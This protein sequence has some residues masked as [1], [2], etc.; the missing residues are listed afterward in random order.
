MKIKFLLEILLQK[1]CRGLVTKKSLAPGD[2]FQGY[3]KTKNTHAEQEP[4]NPGFIR[5][6]SICRLSE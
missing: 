1:I 4:W 6:L 2:F 5:I 3:K